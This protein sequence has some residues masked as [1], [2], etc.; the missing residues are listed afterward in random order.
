MSNYTQT[1]FF[2]PK[3]ALPITD[4]NKT[5]FGAA[6]DVEFA[7][8]SVSIATKYDSSNIATNPILFGIGTALLP[9]ISFT[10]GSNSNTGLYVPAGN[11]VG[12]SAGGV[13]Q[14]TFANGTITLFGTT[15]AGAPTLA[16]TNAS[17]VATQDVLATLN[18]GS[19]V[20]ELYSANQNRATAV[21][22][23]N[24]GAPT[25]AQGVVFTTTGI[26]LVFGTAGKYAGQIGGSTQGLIWG[27][28]T[29]GDKG[30]GTINAA[31]VF[32]NGV[33]VG[34]GGG[35]TPLTSYGTSTLNASSI[36]IGQSAIVVRSTSAST[37]SNVV[38]TNDAVLQI[39]NLPNTGT[40]TFQWFANFTCAAVSVG[41]QVGPAFNGTI[42]WAA[43]FGQWTMVNNTFNIGNEGTGGT[44][45]TCGG[46]PAASGN[47]CGQG[48]G[49]ITYSG[50]SC[51]VILQW[52][53]FSSSATALVIEPNSWLMV[54]RIA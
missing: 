32:V 51:S 53:Q 45:F 16:I 21:V 22:G 20:L 30:V 36:N 14:A 38:P 15:V 41:A 4:P 10:G 40:Y 50:G 27:N 28:P 48:S 13:L 17:T 34:T 26:P 52:C 46:A 19:S 54:T 5:I 9:S 44:G 33:A 8:I 23:T 37:S 6:Y 35:F 11:Q 25:A 2:T 31:G 49:S 39:T 29:G 42:T 1:T 47:S 43:G 18:A 3:D 24:A 7:A 12:V